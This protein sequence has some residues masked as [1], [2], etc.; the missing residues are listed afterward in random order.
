[1]NACMCTDNYACVCLLCPRVANQVPRHL[2]MS[3]PMVVPGGMEYHTDLYRSIQNFN[4]GMGI[5]L[6]SHQSP[7]LRLARLAKRDSTSPWWKASTECRRHLWLPG[8]HHGDP[9]FSTCG[10]RPSAICQLDQVVLQWMLI[11]LLLSSGNGYPEWDVTACLGHLCKVLRIFLTINKKMPVL[12]KTVGPCQNVESTLRLYDE[13][14]CQNS[15]INT[16]PFLGVFDSNRCTTKLSSWTPSSTQNVTPVCLMR[17]SASRRQSPPR[18]ITW[19][20]CRPERRRPVTQTAMVWT[21]WFLGPKN[22]EETLIE[23]SIFRVEMGWT[24]LRVIVRSPF[25]ML[26]TSYFLGKPW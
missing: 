17:V 10:T 13:S 4:D 7:R 18:S 14:F 15:S 9:N 6:W 24:C 21:F 2:A 20:P 19:V 3:N 23:G 12:T 5:I 25:G 16:R 1:M 8:G 22:S 11:P 26:A